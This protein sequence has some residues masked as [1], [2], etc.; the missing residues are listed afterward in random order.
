[1][2]LTIQ[3]GVAP[4]FLG[5]S[6]FA[7]APNNMSNTLRCPFCALMKSGVARSYEMKVIFKIVETRDASLTSNQFELHLHESV[8]IGTSI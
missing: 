4:S 5:T 6:A 3:S 7:P 2:K 8:Y 1:M